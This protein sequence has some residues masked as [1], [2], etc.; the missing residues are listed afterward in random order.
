MP[1]EKYIKKSIGIRKERKAEK[2]EAKKFE[3]DLKKEAKEETK[4]IYQAERRKVI[5]EKA[6]KEGKAKAQGRSIGGIV[7]KA[8]KKLG[9]MEDNKEY[10]DDFLGLKP[11]NNQ[12]GEPRSNNN[13][14]SVLGVPAKKKKK[15]FLDSL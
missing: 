10:I 13:W 15:G 9:K 8:S 11:A 14:D 4:L 12:R 3:S 5:L 2:K 7:R 1:I 6:R